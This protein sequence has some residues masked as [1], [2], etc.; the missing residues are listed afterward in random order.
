V[1]HLVLL[2]SKHFGNSRE[3]YSKK[4]RVIPRRKIVEVTVYFGD[5]AVYFGEV[6]SNGEGGT[7]ALRKLW[8]RSGLPKNFITFPYIIVQYK[9]FHILQYERNQKLRLYFFFCIH[10]DTIQNLRLLI[11]S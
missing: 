4:R 11:L 9:H 8:Y 6:T 2:G 1:L 5:V 10:Y 7:V 3:C